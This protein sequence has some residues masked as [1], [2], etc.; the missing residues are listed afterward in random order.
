MA[1][2]PKEAARRAR[3]A[4]AEQARRRKIAALIAAAN[5]KAA[6]LTPE[7]RE[8]LCALKPRMLKGY[9]DDDVLRQLVELQLAEIKLGGPGLTTIGQFLADRIC[10]RF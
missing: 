9:V 3:A 10:G 7:M 1:V 6:H 5:E 2:T 4:A 8:A